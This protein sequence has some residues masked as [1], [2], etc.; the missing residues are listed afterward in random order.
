VIVEDRKSYLVDV[1]LITVVTIWGFNFPLMKVMYRYFHP[2]AFN[3][4]RFTVCS[5]TMMTVLARDRSNLTFDKAD[6]GRIV[7]LGFLSNTA[8][9]FIFVIGLDRTRAGNAAMLMALTPVFAFLIGVAMRKEHFSSAILAGI[10]ISM[11]G[12]ATIVIFGRSELSFSTS[13]SGDLLMIAAAIFWGWQSAESTRLLPKYGPIRL[14]VF[15]MVAGTLMLLPMS[16][17]WLLAQNWRSIPVTGWL[18]LAYSAL[19]SVTY[20]YFVWSYAIDRIGIAHT[21]VFNNV[22]PIIALFAGWLMLSDRPTMAQLAGVLLVL[23][24][25]FMVRSRKPTAVPDE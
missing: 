13:S 12:A 17:P 21:S 2:I 22:T 1:L 11:T 9:P 4:V 10:A 14:T 18:G 7:W 8:Y 5:L 19:L 23:V 6:L 25:V 3:A 16:V 20:S 15:A 24:G